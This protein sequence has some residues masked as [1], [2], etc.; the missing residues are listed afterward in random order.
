LKL[1][2]LA[3]KLNGADL[4]VDAN[5]GDVA[6]GVGVV[7]KAEQ[8]ARLAHARVAD[9]KQLEKIVAARRR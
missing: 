9:E 6:L 3:A 5:G 7:G 4:K 1:D 2:L 8:Q